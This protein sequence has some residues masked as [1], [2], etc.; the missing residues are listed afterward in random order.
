[1]EETAK[2]DAEKE[3]EYLETVTITGDS[4]R[5]PESSQHISWVESDEL[6]ITDDSQMKNE[7]RDEAQ[8]RD[9]TSKTETAKDMADHTTDNGESGG[10]NCAHP[11]NVSWVKSKHQQGISKRVGGSVQKGS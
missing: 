1:M 2:A 5:G 10:A 3:A 11:V 4:E 9:E 7:K 6:Q 8:R